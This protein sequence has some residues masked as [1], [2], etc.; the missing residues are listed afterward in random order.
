MTNGQQDE[1][2]TRRE[3]GHATR[4]EDGHATRRESALPGAG[5][6]A[7]RHRRDAPGDSDPRQTYREGQVPPGPGQTVGA[8][9]DG[10]VIVGLPPALRD[11]Y[12]VLEELPNPGTEAD[13]LLVHDRAAGGGARSVVKVYRQGMHADPAVWAAI[14]TLGSANIVRFIE[15][16][17]SG[18]RD[19][20]VMEYL[21]G[22]NL[23]QLTS[24]QGGALGLNMVT[25]VVRQVTDGLAELHRNGIVHR[26]LKPENV[27][28]RQ[29][30][31]LDIVVTD[32][33]LSRVHEQS[34]VA[35]SRSGTLAYLA[36]EILLSTGAQ[37]SK[38]RDWWALGMIVRELL[39]GVR[40]FE[41]MTVSG[42]E[43]AL[44]LRPIDLGD[45]DDPRAR[46]LCRGLLIRDPA[47]R[48]SVKQVT[49]WLGGGSPP[50]AADEPAESGAVKPFLFERV[51][52]RERKAL[53]KAFARSW[54]QAAR[55]YFVAMG[56]ESSRSSAWKTLREWL[57]QFGDA[58]ADDVESLY[59]LIDDQLLSDRNS[60]D[61]KLLAL[62]RWLDPNLPPVYRGEWLTRENL[63]AIAGSVALGNDPPAYLTRLIGDLHSYDLLPRL[64]RMRGGDSLAELNS[65][66][67]Q[68]ADMF[69]Q[70]AGIVTPDLP[71]AARQALAGTGDTRVQA[72]LLYLAL[73]PAEHP[74]KLQERVTA[75]PGTLP[76][77]VPWYDRIRDQRRSP[78]DDVVLIALFPAAA[79]ESAAAAQAREERAAAIRQS[80]EHWQER[81]RQRLDGSPGLPR[82]LGYSA[83]VMGAMIL[84]FIIAAAVKSPGAVVVASL[85]TGLAMAGLVTGSEGFLATE[86][87]ADYPAHAPLARSGDMLRRAGD[88][89]HGAGRGC[90]VLI[91]GLLVLGI[92][93]EAPFLAYLIAGGV[94]MLSWN[95][96]RTEWS[97]AHE[98]ERER[99]LGQS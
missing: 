6:N 40:P 71:P 85:V 57:E 42:I 16:G 63:T 17:S 12:T 62:I 98:L 81:E 94:H 68:L 52:Y 50:V 66:W 45:I 47:D 96:R 46:L 13:V 97:R 83:A 37:S 58:E 5:A 39:T 88:Q 35:A 33:G 32:F 73:D 48:W 55:R 99:V 53:A 7:G 86:L 1:H 15:T 26:D 44:L 54:E 30:D 36:P 65:S 95:R 67:R 79:Q 92:C 10:D 64:A 8:G 90:L 21:A 77:P 82:A 93:T 91:L 14:R 28:V 41:E 9:A 72:A 51:P 11:R 27:L 31:P 43:R 78:A 76:V 69:R 61:L 34:M 70:Q 84:L 23:T 4:R 60:P 89:I 25:E 87:G 80:Q 18:G 20:E 19:Y 75:Y 56:A 22:G 49:K 2:A 38:A 24:S 74:G 59:E 29:A 3:E